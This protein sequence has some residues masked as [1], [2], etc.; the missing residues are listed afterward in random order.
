MAKQG[1]LISISLRAVRGNAKKKKKKKISLQN[2]QHFSVFC[3][4]WK[5]IAVISN[6]WLTFRK[7]QGVVLAQ[8][9]ICLI[10][11]LHL[12]E[13]QNSMFI[14]VHSGTLNYYVITKWLKFR[15]PSPLGRTRLILVPRPPLVN[16]QRFTSIPCTSLTK[17]VNSVI[18]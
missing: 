1:V 12:L 6:L 7:L 5:D 15:S 2:L 16:V 8:G 9:H 13:N 18:W 11:F 14:K 10:K 4:V 17:T 3:E